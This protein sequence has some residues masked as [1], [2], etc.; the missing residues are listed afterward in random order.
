MISNSLRDISDDQSITV[1]HRLEAYNGR[2]GRVDRS[3]LIYI[4]EPYINGFKKDE[5]GQLSN[6][7]LKNHIRCGSLMQ[8]YVTVKPSDRTRSQVIVPMSIISRER[9]TNDRSVNSR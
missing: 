2:N 1:E 8:D 9:T 3:N 7:A 5:A 4:N 6:V